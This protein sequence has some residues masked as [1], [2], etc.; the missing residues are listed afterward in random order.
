MSEEERDEL[1]E[2]LRRT[3]WNGNTNLSVIL[4]AARNIMDRIPQVYHVTI[5]DK[6]SE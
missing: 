2:E 5:T 6:D 1:I 3:L 4:R